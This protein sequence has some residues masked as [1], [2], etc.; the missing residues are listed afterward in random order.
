MGGDST[1]PCCGH[2]FSKARSIRYA[3]FVCVPGPAKAGHYVRVGRRAGTARDD[4][5][6]YVMIAALVIERASVFVVS[7]FSRTCFD[8]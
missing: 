8:S 6:T 5:H 7:G 1:L 2:P 3:A 4:W